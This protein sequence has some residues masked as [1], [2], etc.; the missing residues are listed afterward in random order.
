MSLDCFQQ[1]SRRNCRT[2]QHAEQYKN[3]SAILP[4]HIIEVNQNEGN[5]LLISNKNENKNKF[6]GLILSDSM[7]IDKNYKKF[8]QLLKN[9]SNE[10]NFEII[11]ANLQHQHMHQDGLHPS[12]TSDK[13]DHLPTNIDY[14]V[15]L[16]QNK[17]HYNKSKI[18]QQINQQQ[19]Q[20]DITN[21]LL[22]IKSK[23][24][25]NNYRNNINNND[26][27]N[28]CNNYTIN[29]QIPSKTLI[30]QYPHFLRHKAQFER[31]T[32][33]PTDLEKAEKWKIYITAAATKKKIVEQ[34]EQMETILEENNRIP[35]TR[36]SPTGLAD[37]PVSLDFNDYK[38]IF[39]EWLPEPMPRQKQELGHRRDDPPTPP[40]PRQPPL[41]IPRKTLPPRDKNAP[42]VG[43]S[44]Q[45]SPISTNSN[46]N[47]R[48]Q[49]YS[50]N[51]LLPLEKHIEIEQ[52]EMRSPIQKTTKE[53]SIMISP[54]Q[55]STP[56]PLVRSPSVV[57]KNNNIILHSS[58][59]FEI[60]PIEYQMRGK[61]IREINHAA[62]PAQQQ[63]IRT[64]QEKFMRTLD[65]KLQL[66]KL[67]M[68]FMQ[69]MPP[70]S[71]NIFDKLQLYAKEL[72]PDNNYL[73]PLRE[74]WKNILRRTKLDLTTLMRQAKVV[75]L[76]QAHKEY[77]ELL[78]E[79]PE[80]YRE[81]YDTLNH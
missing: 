10:M 5:N 68:R 11:N 37:R 40:L 21:N 2:I 62:T 77:E 66:D 41:I 33:I 27:N 15:Q 20:Q 50:F 73:N 49:Q 79:L 8:N 63:H 17:N 26:N 18:Y 75:E 7:Y 16:N 34:I 43:G 64:L 30:N 76:E 60:I 51:T 45:S 19:Q 28:I 53:P 3:R 65:L 39:E 71:L 24:K 13:N 48:K 1:P 67:E 59:N 56:A 74:Q 42:I 9:L 72:K 70:P 12:I 38:E 57:S 55:S 35:I 61:A 69:N 47:N 54:L 80:N 25:K 46:E 4:C 78:K 36:P 23:I 44:L 31:K 29:E 32:S 52:P 6:N 81:P 14:S 58:Y 22:S